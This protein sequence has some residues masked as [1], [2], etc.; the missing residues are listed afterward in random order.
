[1][2]SHDHHHELLGQEYAEILYS[3]VVGSLVKGRLFLSILGVKADKTNKTTSLQN[4]ESGNITA[5]T[6]GG[7]FATETDFKDG[8]REK[9][10][11]FLTSV[12]KAEVHRDGY[13][14]NN[15]D[16]IHPCILTILRLINDCIYQHSH[17]E[18]RYEYARKLLT[19][20]NE[21]LLPPIE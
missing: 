16:I 15:D 6:L 5:K 13:D 9:L 21:K 11:K 12:N 20:I 3:V 1:M 10:F 19:D 8:E 17:R 2:L 7:R 14:E 18:I 4:E